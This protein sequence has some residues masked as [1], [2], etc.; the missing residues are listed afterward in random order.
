MPALFTGSRFVVVPSRSDEGLPLVA[1]E[2]MAAGR[3]LIVTE[4]GGIR[5][6]VDDGVQGLIVDRE[7]APAL[8]VAI[9]RLLADDGIVD[10]LATAGAR[11]SVDFD[12]SV[13]AERY[14]DSFS[15][16]RASR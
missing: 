8:A 9:D 15:A 13:L 7:D 6:A 11:R 5:E 16:A 1:L 12:W 14:L 10:R 2:A 3:A 4:S